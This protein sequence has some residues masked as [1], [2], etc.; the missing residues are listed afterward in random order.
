MKRKISL[1]TQMILNNIL[2]FIL[3]VLILGYVTIYTSNKRIEQDIKYDNTIISNYINNQI[4]SFIQNPI[5]MMNEI[6]ESLLS[7]KFN[8]NDK[9][10][11]YLNTIINIYPYFDTVKIIDK[12]GVVKNIA[13]Y[14][15][16]YVGTSV[17]HEE[18]FSKI[19]K[20]GKPKFSKVF[21]SERTHKPTVNISIYIN[22][23]VLVAD[24]NLSKIKNI[25]DGTHIGYVD[26]IS[27]LDENGIYL[28][29]DNY[30]NV[31]QRINFKYFDKM[32]ES[33]KHKESM[34]N[35]WENK[36]NLVYSTKIESTGWYSVISIK[37]DKAFE[38]VNKLRKVLYML[39][40]VLLIISLIISALS[41]RK[42][43]KALKNLLDK[44]KLISTGDYN[45]DSE[46]KGYSEFEELSRYFDVM[47]DNVKERENR[48]QALN[49]ELEE[50]V[51]ERTSQLEKTNVILE[52]EILERQRIE[53]EIKDLNNELENKVIERTAEILR[54]NESL[55]ET[56]AA[57][58]EEIV[59]RT[60]VENE[61]REAKKEAESANK[62]KSQ[63][64]ANMS[65]EIRTPMNGIMGMTELALMCDLDPKP[66]EYL[67]LVMKSSKSLLVIIN[68]VLDYSKIEAGKII[69]E[70]TS[71]RI[72]D[73]INEVIRL[74]DISAKQKGIELKVNID[75]AVPEVLN[76]DS[77]RLRQVL[78]N[79]I[80]NAVKFTQ[81]G[82]V[83]L[84]VII[85]S[86]TEDLIKLKFSVKDTGIGVPMNKQ[87]LLF[88]RF[89]QLDS[90]Y[91]KKYQGTGL[92]LAISKN[93]V[94]LM[95]GDIWFE[96]K[97]EKGSTFKFTA[98]LKKIQHEINENPMV[99]NKSL[100]NSNSNKLVLLV[101]DDKINQ[102]VAELILKHKK[103][104]I[105]I[106]ENGKKAI[107]LY[108][109]YTF[110]L[111]LMDIS[112]PV[113]DGCTATLLIREKERATSVHTPII[114]MTAYAL[115]GERE[116]IMAAGMDDYISK[117]IH[118]SD[119]N[120]KI[121]KY[122]G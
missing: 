108:D 85:N 78:S 51:L 56:N 25:I 26:H 2:I 64:L 115:T 44:T 91:T 119:L 42:I 35:V 17:L 113:M 92:G 62:A 112:M 7:K 84:R 36:R 97:E 75:K 94:K 30:D 74:F 16:E 47:K 102:R 50:R 1:K 39:L 90:S 24:L 65:H 19:D 14:N 93:L 53:E 116:K 88:E 8:D 32:N 95:G 52:E 18:F 73:V 45:D 100:E 117:P 58:E 106:A 48:I 46:Y 38:Y 83:E 5:N 11:E 27:I 105:V 71:F 89:T 10:N 15:N 81:L 33:I 6:R 59:E 12:N 86:S 68:D 79:L 22:G 104:Q 3:P 49:E 98:T 72:K 121:D 118:V 41:V 55:E 120:K 57:L 69:I 109:N 21:I 37:S 40:V 23:D 82:Y 114:A 77:V 28:V 67:S 66:R 96:N 99:L 13:P 20:T 122:L 54:T 101:E 80:G 9:I 107:E 103:L 111:I 34:I 29:D 63:F 87:G 76:G 110:D 60:R 4:A 61:L 70:S 43:T 31:S